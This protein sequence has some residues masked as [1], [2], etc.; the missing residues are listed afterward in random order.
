MAAAIDVFSGFKEWA[1]MPKKNC[2]PGLKAIKVFIK[3]F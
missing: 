1:F 2:V 3:K